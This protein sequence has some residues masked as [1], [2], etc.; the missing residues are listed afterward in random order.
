MNGL[1]CSLDRRLNSLRLQLLRAVL[2]LLASLAAPVCFAQVAVEGDIVF[3]MSGPPI[4][5]GVV[6]IIDGRITA[7]GPQAD[8]TVPDDFTVVR[9]RV[10][11]PGLIDTHS[12]VGLSGILNSDHDQDQLESSNPIQPELRAI[13]AY[14]TAEELIG[15]VRGFGVTTLH[16]GHAPGELISGQTF[17]VKTMGNTVEDAVISPATALAVTLS[18]AEQKSGSKSPGTRGKSVAMLRSELI[19]AREYLRKSRTA[20]AD[21]EVDPPDRDLRLEALGQAL[22]GELAFMVTADRAQDILSA[23]RLAEEFELRL[24]LD[25]AA[26]AYR[27][28]DEI[29]AAGVPVLVHPTMARAVGTRENLTFENAARLVEAGIR[30]GLQSGYEPYVPKT[31]VVLFEAGMAAANGLTLE[32]ALRTVTADAAEI[33]GISDRVGSLRVG[34]DGNVAVYDGDPFEYTTHCTA[35]VIEGQVFPGES[36]AV[37]D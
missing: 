30:V 11:T 36:H 15:W 9:G 31:R 22:Q 5:D 23:L 21:P 7:I 1:S 35:V 33:L 25:S 26:E 10:V 27:V 29:A 4:N 12:V 28:R 2:G 16:T 3:S 14:N 34:L 37:A 24:W 18:T 8:I 17:I 13:D 19:R 6:V 32:Q 20:A